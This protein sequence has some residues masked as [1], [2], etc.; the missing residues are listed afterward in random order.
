MRIIAG[1]FRRRQLAA[2][3]GDTTRPLTDRAKEHLFERLG[4]FDDQRV[5]DV[6][7]G[8]GTIGL[9]AMSRGAVA[10]VFVER[11]HRAFELL[12]HNVRTLGVQDDAFCWRA[13][14]LRCSFRPKGRPELL[15][16]DRIFFDPPYPITDQLRPG[17]PLFRALLRLTRPDVAA[18]GAEL[19]LRTPLRQAIV[20]PDGWRPHRD[21]TLGGMSITRYLRDSPGRGD[22][23]AESAEE[24]RSKDDESE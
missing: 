3:P 21:M 1:R 9:E 4:T 12:C 22:G 20:V 2:A 11:D 5:L 8:T 23:A 10:A 19:I 6:F 24:P 17:T 7:A 16:F 13:D 14:V 18:D 15:P